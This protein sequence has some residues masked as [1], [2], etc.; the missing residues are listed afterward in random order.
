MR[1]FPRMHVQRRTSFPFRFISLHFY[2]TY[3]VYA[4]ARSR[5]DRPW[6]FDLWIPPGFPTKLLETGSVSWI[7]TGRPIIRGRFLRCK[8]HPTVL[9]EIHRNTDLRA[10]YFGVQLRGFVAPQSRLFIAARYLCAKLTRL[11]EISFSSVRQLLQE[12]GYFSSRV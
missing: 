7:S 2:E 11:Q 6:N 12:E 4:F 10:N 1:Y 5:R 9:L 3:H 8:Y